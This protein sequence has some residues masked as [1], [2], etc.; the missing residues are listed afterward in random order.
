MARVGGLKF[1]SLFL[2]MAVA[3]S[4]YRPDKQPEVWWT[5]ALFFIAVHVL[6]LVAT[7]LVSPWRTTPTATLVMAAVW[8]QIAMV[9]I[10]MGYHRLWTHRAFTARKPLRI[11]LALMGAM[12]FQGSIRWWVVRHR[13]HHRYTDDPLNDPYAITRGL[14]YSHVG[15][16]FTKPSYPRWN[17]VDKGDLDRD[18]VVTLQHKHYIPI[19]LFMSFVLPT[20]VSSLWG[21]ALGGFV[22]GGLFARIIIWHC[23]FTVNSLAHWQGAQYY[24]NEMSGRGDWL[25]AALTAGE[26]NHNF[27]HA[28]PSDY[29]N[30]PFLASWDPTRWVILTLHKFTSQ[31]P[32]LRRTEELD[33]LKARLYMIRTE[34]ASISDKDPVA[35]R[36]LER[37]AQVLQ[38]SLP[39]QEITKG[40][41]KPTWGRTELEDFVISERR[42][43]ILIEGHAVDVTSFIK[44]HPGG[45]SILQEYTVFNID[46]ETQRQQPIRDATQAFLGR[47]NNH[48]RGAREKMRA[49]R[50]A[51]I[52]LPA[53]DVMEFL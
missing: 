21:D 37:R 28:F 3:T 26:G 35:A 20:A 46:K 9:G 17:L 41:E 22:W 8:Y 51:A 30:A 43:V 18:V 5:N 52:S 13:L 44:E 16:I 38:S 2:C 47:F 50:V 11:A 19:A 39:V 49:L 4:T 14:V 25:I 15:W 45:A 27:H 29:R 23:I 24:T 7:L 36:E 48:T 10:T 40:P 31:I 6:A 34:A 12:G 42:T 33:V 32:S 1:C 53:D